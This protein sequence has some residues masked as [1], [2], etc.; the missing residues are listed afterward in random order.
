MR[1]H[2]DTSTPQHI[3]SRTHRHVD[4]G[5]CRHAVVV[6]PPAGPLLEHVRNMTVTKG[7]KFRFPS[8]RR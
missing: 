3:D 1:I 5:E 2:S 8:N 7:E 4:I 6:L